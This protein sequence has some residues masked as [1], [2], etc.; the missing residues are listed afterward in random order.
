MT[1][2]SEHAIVKCVRRVDLPPTWRR[3][4]FSLHFLM[5]RDEPCGAALLEVYRWAQA[6][7]LANA[8]AITPMTLL[9]CSLFHPRFYAAMAHE[10]GMAP[11]GR[12]RLTGEADDAVSLADD[13]ATCRFWLQSVVFLS[14]VTLSAAI[15]QG[16]WSHGTLASKYDKLWRAGEIARLGAVPELAGLEL[17]GRVQA[18]AAQTS[19]QAIDRLLAIRLLF[20]EVVAILAR[21]V[22]AR[23]V[24]MTPLHASDPRRARFGFIDE[25]REQVG[26]V[27]AIVVYGSSVSSEHFADYDLALIVDD[28]QSVLRALEN[29]CPRWNG[30]ELN[31]GVYSPDEFWRMQ[32][33][34][35]DNLAGYGLCVYGEVQVPDKPA[36]ALLARNLS[37][38]MVRQRQQLGM[39]CQAVA[40]L[41]DDGDDRRN[42]YDY[43]IKIPANVV[44][45]TFGAVGRLRPKEEV[46]RWLAERC[47]F[48]TAGEQ[49][50]AAAA[51]PALPLARSAVATGVALRTLNDELGIV[52]CE[53]NKET[54]SHE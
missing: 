28:P 50:R 30:K 47:G 15:I 35:G 32:L 53:S 1:I 18:L 22:S 54:I 41:P 31:I 29:R 48:D 16:R 36:A 37:F 52:R 11:Q 21:G 40:P 5:L 34:S 38:G 42:L 23:P 27:R 8:R 24:L 6:Q 46:Q 49:A 12:I 26:G 14:A 10:P 3:E 25:L 33:L 2:S 9:W 17:C 20:E 13:S 45:G 39:L 4:Q 19:A 43:F 44:K 51:G 7:G